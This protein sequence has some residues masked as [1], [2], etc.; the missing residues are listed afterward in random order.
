MTSENKPKLS[1]IKEMEI[2]SSKLEDVVSLAQGIPSFRTPDCIK[3]KIIEKM[4]EG[5]TDF[6]SLSPGL[7]ELREA[8]EYSLSHEGISYD[9]ENEIII[10]AGSIE[11]ITASFLAVLEPGDEVIIPDPTYT[12][13]QDAIKTA[14]GVPVF[15]PLSEEKGW[16]FD[17]EELKKKIGPKTKAILFCNPNNP[18]G[19]IYTETQIGEILRLAEKHNLYVL[20]DEVYRDFIFDNENFFSIGKFGNFRERFILIFS[21]SKAYSMTG[22]R[23]AYLATE[24]KL[25]KRILAFH[26]AMVTCAPVASQWGALAAIEL[27]GGDKKN[28]LKRLEGR[29]KMICSQLDEMRDYLE[30]KKPNSAY[31]VFPKF[32]KKLR[33]HLEKI[34]ADN[35]YDLEDEKKKS[36]SWIFSMELLYKQKLTVVPGKAFGE[37][38][39]EHIRLCFGRSEEDI[40]KGMRR[41]REYFEKI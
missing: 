27:A 5:K 19:T 9:F 32:S 17:V 20:A 28:F 30:Y 26:D 35:E 6:Y 22:W 7:L 33:E 16:A 25:A 3:E 40:E 14:K 23:V 15:A 24:K 38:G 18:T 11:A 1:A 8:I 10:T 36:L 39:E 4:G 29:R 31:F 13:F 21:F 37:N 41:L 12:S 34:Q 2:R